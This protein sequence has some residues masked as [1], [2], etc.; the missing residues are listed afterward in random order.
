M[1]AK[2]TDGFTPKAIT[3]AS[4]EELPK[5]N[6]D[7]RFSNRIAFGLGVK[8]SESIY[9]PQI[10]QLR[11][12][13][14]KLK[15]DIELTGYIDFEVARGYWYI[16]KAKLISEISQLTAKHERLVKG[17]KEITTWMYDMQNNDGKYIYDH[18]GTVVFKSDIQKLL[19][20][21]ED[22]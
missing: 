5:G 3:E 20:E 14:E 1:T 4:M 21:S 17:M 18:H 19:T 22:K 2:M 15:K 11:E 7:T 9:L 16:E 13:I 6:L 10:Q 12:E 8:Y